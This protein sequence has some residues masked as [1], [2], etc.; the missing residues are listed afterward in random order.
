MQPDKLISLSP[1]AVRVLGVLIEKEKTTPDN[2]PL[3]LNS[4]V[5]GCN[6]STNRNPV[7]SYD[8]LTI[9]RALTELR[10]CSLAKRGVYAGSRV[11]KHRHSLE[12]VVNISSEAL[13][14]LAVL[15]LRGEQTLG[16]IK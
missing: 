13:A 2:Y 6:Q 15:L 4:L 8:E 11:P 12:E 9:E 3:T 5:S 1:E 14:V 7:V 10:D 16:E